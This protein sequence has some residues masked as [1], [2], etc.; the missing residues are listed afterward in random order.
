MNTISDYLDYN[1]IKSIIK[2]LEHFFTIESY[3]SFCEKNKKI[4]YRTTYYLL[5]IKYGVSEL[6]NHGIIKNIKQITIDILKEDNILIPENI[7][8]KIIS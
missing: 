8:K 6:L 2:Y 1:Q 7:L 3:E 5:V 4:Y